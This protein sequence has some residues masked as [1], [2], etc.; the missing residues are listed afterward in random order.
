MAL[1]G[2]KKKLLI[3]L[4]SAA[5]VLQAHGVTVREIEVEG[6]KKTNPERFM[7]LLERYK[8]KEADTAAVTETILRTGI[9]ET[10][11]TEVTEEG[12]LRIKVKEKFSFLPIPFAS[13][14]SGT[15]MGGLVIMDNN[16]FGLMNSL[17]AGGFFSDSS[18]SFF[19]GYSHRQG[20]D[21]PF[22]W[23]F[24]VNS[25]KTD[26]ET[27]NE[28]G[29]VLHRYSGTKY[30]IS[31]GI[32]CRPLPGIR[33]ETKA[34]YRT[35]DGEPSVPASVSVSAGKSSWNGIFMNTSSLDITAEHSFGSEDRSFSSITVKGLWEQPLPGRLRLT[36]EAGWFHAPDIPPEYAE[37][38]SVTGI[39]LLGSR[40]K[41]SSAASCGAGLEWCA[42]NLPFGM[43]TLYGQYQLAYLENVTYGETPAHG[44]VA[45]IRFYLKKIAF[46]AINIYTSYNADTGNLRT[47][48][49]A[50]FSF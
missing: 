28:Y 8:G 32:S 16:A 14:S 40:Y 45:G 37:S 49:G 25:G 41:V 24:A 26:A 13:A 30:G 2:L 29:T 15:Y 6:L 31:G 17:A 10:P 34:G 9:F 38:P 46:P 18:Y 7:K 33:L 3:I 11:E 36:A 19:A 12:T 23:Q 42:L 22:G 48:A 47:S 44:P 5:V 4:F 20:A 1:E 27:E 21:E 50:G 43:L 39:S 35:F